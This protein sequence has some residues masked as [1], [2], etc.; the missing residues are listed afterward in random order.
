VRSNASPPATASSGSHFN[1]GDSRGLTT[2][3]SGWV[4]FFSR[5]RDFFKIHHFSEETQEN[6]QKFPSQGSLA[7]V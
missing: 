6:Q 2:I 7:G 4:A 1:F 3:P 5:S